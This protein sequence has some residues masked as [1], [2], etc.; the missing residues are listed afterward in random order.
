MLASNKE[1]PQYYGIDFSK[2]SEDDLRLVPKPLLVKVITSFLWI[3]DPVWKD[4]Q[5]KAGKILQE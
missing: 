3:R 2:V 1:R 5:K 4:L